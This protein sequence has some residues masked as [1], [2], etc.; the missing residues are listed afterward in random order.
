M[1]QYGR[2]YAPQ[3]GGRAK[4]I[5]ESTSF[6]D[7]EKSSPDEGTQDTQKDHGSAF[8]YPRDL[9]MPEQAIPTKHLRGETSMKRREPAKNVP[10]TIRKKRR[11]E[12]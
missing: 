3:Y 2:F 8:W 5:E 12:R 6:L 11:I 4:P 7:T 1:K 10:V 9:D